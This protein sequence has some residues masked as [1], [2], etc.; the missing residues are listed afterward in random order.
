[1]RIF[2][3]QAYDL[4]ICD[5]ET[6]CSKKTLIYYHDNVGSFLKYLAFVHQS[7]PSSLLLDD[8]SNKILAE[9]IRYLRSKNKFEHH[10]I[11]GERNQ[12]LKNTS[13]RT[14]TRAVKAF[15]N[16]CN[17]E[18]DAAFVTSVKLPKDDSEEKIPLYDSEVEM[19]DKLFNL[20]TVTGCRNYCIFHLMID[21]GLRAG[22][23]VNLR[24]CDVLFDK[25]LIKIQNSKGNRSRMV[26]LPA[27]LKKQLYIYVYMHR[28]FIDIPEY[29]KQPVFMQIKKQEY[30][31]YNCIKLLFRRIKQKTEINRLTPHLL[32]HTFAT[33]YIMGGGNLENLRLLL[34]HYDYTVTREYLHLANTYRLLGASVYKLDSIYFKTIY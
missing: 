19:I 31:N 20:K 5:R 18:F 6:F 14:Y 1:M 10:P 27:K 16:F 17:L 2:L 15:L 33:S 34:G 26:L 4:F 30:I 9:Y 25:N 3:Q 8:V 7:D 32:R 22:E 29:E 21:V 28:D 23:V 11:V 24:I 13:I 12:K